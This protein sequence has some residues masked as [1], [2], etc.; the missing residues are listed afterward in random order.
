MSHEHCVTGAIHTGNP[1][2]T[3]Q[4][5]SDRKTYVTGSNKSNALLYLTDVFGYLYPNHRLLADTFASELPLT[6]YVP[7]FL[8]ESAFANL[9]NE[10]RQ[11]VDFA[12][13]VAFNPKEKR[14][15][16]ILAFAEYL[17]S[18]YEKVFV[19]GYCWGGWGAV[20]LAAK[21]GFITAVSLNHPSKLEIPQDLE[22]LTS[23]TLIVAPYT[24]QAFTQEARL[25]AEKI[26][27]R[28][29]QEDKLFFKISVYPGFVHGFA[30]RGD[31][32]D[33]FSNGA[34]EDA[35]SETVLFFN[36]FIK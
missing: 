7:D 4:V 9:S 14:Y 1:V 24:D 10:E 32:D 26:F 15:P 28:K 30:A 16:Q 29:A 8:E 11:N 17:K 36:R 35:K 22:N 6:V 19:V 13:F 23:P 21:P 18:K 27:D 25:I 33:A 3:E 20:M 34:I 12:K 2:G 31:S 5:I